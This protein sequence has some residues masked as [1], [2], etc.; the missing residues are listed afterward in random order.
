MS[1]WNRPFFPVACADASLY[2]K[3][4]Y[5]TMVRIAGSSFGI[6]QVF[7]VA[8][9]T[10]GWTHIA[11][12][13]DEDTSS[14]CW[15][16]SKPLDDLIGGNENYSLTWFRLGSNPTDGQLDDTLQQI[17]SRARGIHG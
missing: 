2:D 17:R 12:L 13:S 6:A 4:K 9:D 16:T 1:Y 15:Y 10:Y 3:A 14:S 11:M 7:K 8:A 5:D